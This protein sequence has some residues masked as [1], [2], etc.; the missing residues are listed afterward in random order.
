MP[1]RKRSRVSDSEDDYEAI[2]DDSDASYSA[3]APKTSNRPGKRAKAKPAG[4]RT[5]TKS[6]VVED[7]EESI[8][9]EPHAA[10]L[11]VISSPE[12]LRAAL[13]DWYNVVHDV[14]GMPWRKRYDPSLGA[15]ERSQRAYEVWV[16][17]IMLQQTQVATVIPYYN[18]WMEKFPTIEHLADA[19]DETVKALWKGLGYYSRA[20]RLHQGAQIAVKDFGGRLPTNAKEM[21]AKISGIGR[22]SAGAI[23][24]IAYNECAPVLDGNVHRLMSR[25]LALH[26]PP[27]SKQTLDVLW[28]G[29]E[30]MVKRAEHPGDINQALIE[31]GSTV[32]KPRDPACSKCPLNKWCQGYR[33][34][35]E[36]SM[37]DAPDIEELCTLCAPVTADEEVGSVTIYPMKAERKKARE[38]MD[39]VNVV[40]WR[41]KNTNERWFLLVRRPESGLL[42]GLQEF[43]SIPNISST[44]SKLAEAPYT[45]LEGLLSSPPRK[46]KAAQGDAQSPRITRV[47]PAGDVIHVFSHIRK[48]YRVQWV[49][50]E[51]GSENGS[52]PPA[53]LPRPTITNDAPSRGPES[54][55]PKG[56]KNSVNASASQPAVIAQ[57]VRLDEVENANIS[58]GVLKIW[59][60]VQ[61]M[62]NWND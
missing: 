54:K 23:C 37:E 50:L 14:R 59:K 52:R 10:S 36:E 60:Q 33:L 1:A 11:H 53:L 34:T 38:E 40:E 19:D 15:E 29:A 3:H 45:L 61:S 46:Q 18:R 16:S 58:T 8:S 9:S 20:T 28:A 47:K 49:L 48:T 4:K 30:A 62:W 56:K 39:S 12:P 31:L 21:E 2:D 25:L 42:A 55:K 27:K 26:S 5:K 41:H 32:C 51:G 13:L 57:W 6:A 35:K 44:A 24:S 43:P 7:A 17:E 22:Y